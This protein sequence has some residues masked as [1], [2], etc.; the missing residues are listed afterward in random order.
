LHA[1]PQRVVVGALVGEAVLG[2]PQVEAVAPKSEPNVGAVEPLGASGGA[3]AVD[4]GSAALLA[5]RTSCV[6]IGRAAAGAARRRSLATGGKQQHGD[7]RQRGG[8]RQR[9]AGRKKAERKKAGH[10]SA[11]GG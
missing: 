8:R 3:G 6:G 5:F 11:N 1:P 9:A 4:E 2:V 7:Q 10:L